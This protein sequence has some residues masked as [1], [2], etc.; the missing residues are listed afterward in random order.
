[1]QALEGKTVFITGASRGIGEAI[2]LRAARDGAN[3]VIAAKTTE[4]HP[5]LPGTIYTTA[6]AVEAAGGHALAVRLDVRDDEAWRHA[7]ETTVE[8]FGGI[9]VVVHNASAIALAPTTEIDMKRFDLLHAVN[10]RA[11]FLGSKLCIPWLERAPNPHILVLCPPPTFSP[12]WYGPHLAYTLSKIGMSLCVVGLAEELRPRGIAVNG[13]WP[14]TTIGTAAIRN[15]LGGEEAIRRSRR[16]EVVA[17]AAAWILA[18][19]SADYTGNFA[20]D[21][22]ILRAAGTTDFGPYAVSAGA[23]LLPDFFIEP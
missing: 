7:I 17:D 13:L 3:V 15:L 16:P 4:P 23:E 2:A 9:D 11:T 14:R 19:P 22:E 21:E 20:I 5:R 8:R 10:V 1:M 12:R 18:R 6:A